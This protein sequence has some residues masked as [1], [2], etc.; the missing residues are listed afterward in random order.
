MKT[1]KEIKEE[2]ETF[3]NGKDTRKEIIDYIDYIIKICQDDKNEI[4]KMIEGMS[5]V[6]LVLPSFKD[7]YNFA[8]E[9]LLNKLK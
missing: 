3:V 7:G 2:L 5:D 1:N 6:A 9:E 4:I 8:K